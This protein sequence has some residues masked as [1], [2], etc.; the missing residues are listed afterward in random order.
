MKLKRC[1]YR[2][3][4]PVLALLVASAGS[5][6]GKESEASGEGITGL[7]AA[8][9]R[10]NKLYEQGDYDGAIGAF[11]SL[12]RKG[13]VDKDLYY[14]LGNAYYKRGELGKAVLHYERALWIAP[15]DKDARENLAFVE[16]LLRDRQFIR[17]QNRF[18]RAL[19]W[20]NN[21]LNTVVAVVLTSLFYVLFCLLL[22][23]FVFRKSSFVVSLYRR[24]S[25][26]SPGRFLGLTR[27]Q[28]LFLAVAITLCLFVGS[29]VSAYEKV[30]TERSRDR[31]VVV[32]PEISV[33]SGPSSESTLQFKIHEGTRVIIRAERSEWVQVELPGDLSG[34]V[35][36]RKIEGI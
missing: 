5:V 21:N 8:F 16:S 29:I 36:S 6:S 33:F 27:E 7:K 20:I 32:A 9:E 17:K 35:M 3:V 19:V 30:V 10:G 28:D 24:L 18:K 31:A 23:S 25:I 15:R 4:L 13:V 14:N 1:C 26:L 12:I 2:I 11:N 34:W 22:V